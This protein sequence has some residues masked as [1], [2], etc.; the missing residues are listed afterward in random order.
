ML[1]KVII[2]ILFL[3]IV[4]SLTGGAVFLFKDLDISESKRTVYLLGLRIT[5]AALLLIVIGY[6]IQSGQL[7]NKAP[8]G[9]HRSF[10][11]D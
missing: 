10:P 1:L 8:W 3:A 5:L 6:G 4:A 11:Q 2:V 9:G 7:V